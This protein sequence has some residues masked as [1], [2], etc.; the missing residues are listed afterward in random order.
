VRKRNVRGMEEEEISNQGKVKRAIRKLRGERAMGQDGISGKV[1]RYEGEW[2]NGYGVFAIGCE[3]EKLARG[4][5]DSADNK[6]GR[7]EEG[8]R[9]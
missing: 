7:K 5:E 1:W 4:L 9:L 6:K 2:K 8:G 3:G